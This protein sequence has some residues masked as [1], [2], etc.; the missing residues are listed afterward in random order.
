MTTE[1]KNLLSAFQ[2]NLA[3]VAKTYPEELK[4]DI[5]ADIA[6][7]GSIS[8]R[9]KYSYSVLKEAIDELKIGPTSVIILD[10][11]VLTMC[12]DDIRLYLEDELDKIHYLLVRIE[13]LPYYTKVH[14]DINLTEE[15]GTGT[16][17]LEDYL[18]E[19]PFGLYY[20][21]FS[22]P[23]LHLTPELHNYLYG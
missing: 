14:H 9:E 19:D 7:L 17:P 12:E 20:W 16:K 21:V 4:A 15:G 13:N 11:F 10:A 23:E 2:V 5:R 6:S 1:S 22:G 8:G 3:K 18:M